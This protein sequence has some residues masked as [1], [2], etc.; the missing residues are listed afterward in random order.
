MSFVIFKKCNVL[1]IRQLSVMLEVLYS[2]ILNER[3]IVSIH[4]DRR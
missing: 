1:Q 2:G 3:G 4:K